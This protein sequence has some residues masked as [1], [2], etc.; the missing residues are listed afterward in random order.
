M[1]TLQPERPLWAQGSPHTGT[2]SRPGKLLET[3]QPER[4]LWAQG[5]PHT[6]TVSKPGKLLAIPVTLRVQ[7]WPWFMALLWL[8]RWPPELKAPWAAVPGLGP[9]QL[10]PPL[11][12][13][14]PGKQGLFVLEADLATSEQTWFASTPFP[15]LDVRAAVGQFPSP[16]SRRL[17]QWRRLHSWPTQP[18]WSFLVTWRGARPGFEQSNMGI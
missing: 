10:C 12:A 13:W 3:L 15:D 5:S 11:G 9:L 14:A 2:V 6:G 7:A 18:V 17:C 1:E 4:P 8:E 16:G